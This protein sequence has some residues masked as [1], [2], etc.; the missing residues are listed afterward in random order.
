MHDEKQPVSSRLIAPVV[1]HANRIDARLGQLP[2]QCPLLVAKA[3]GP[4][5]GTV[6]IIQLQVWLNVA[7]GVERPDVDGFLF[8]GREEE[9]VG[10]ADGKVRTFDV[11]GSA[12]TMGV[13]R[14]V[15]E[16]L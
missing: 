2:L 5:P 6:R 8:G 11:G 3:I 10:L 15:A 12:G 1:Q 13:A 4:Q 14:A 7:L 16:R 9:L